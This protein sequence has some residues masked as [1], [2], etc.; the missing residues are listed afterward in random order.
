MSDEEMTERELDAW[1]GEHLFGLSVEWA[2]WFSGPNGAC[3]ASADDEGSKEPFE[4]GEFDALPFYS[5]DWGAMHAVVAA[6]QERGFG[7][8]MTLGGQN[9]IDTVAF[10]RIG[11]SVYAHANG[12]RIK[13]ESVAWHVAEAARQALI[14]EK[15]V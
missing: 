1:L 15:V 13:P 7:F 6:M 8:S 4:V 14:S 9:P 5:D 12:E 11:G 2:A 10:G 3:R